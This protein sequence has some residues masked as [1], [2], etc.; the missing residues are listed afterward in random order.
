MLQR[1]PTLGPE[2]PLG[3]L[4]ASVHLP[5]R[6]YASWNLSV[7]LYTVN[8]PWLFSLL[9]CAGVP[10]VTSDNAHT[11]SQVPSPLWIMV[12]W[13]TVRGQRVPGGV[14]REP[15]AWGGGQAP[16]SGLSGEVSGGE[17]HVRRILMASGVC[18]KVRGGGKNLGP[19]HGEKNITQ[20]P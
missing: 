2:A 1:R 16:C 20:G 4:T 17:Q 11:L 5:H 15:V 10:S 19:A 8:T 14:Q 7:N 3:G 13:G 12:S 18:T 9:W 6:D